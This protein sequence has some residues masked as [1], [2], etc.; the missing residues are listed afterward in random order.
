MVYLKFESRAYAMLNRRQPNP[1]MS[2]YTYCGGGALY[3]T[4]TTF[5]LRQQDASVLYFK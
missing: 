4:Y 5:Q 3:T 1:K 2:K